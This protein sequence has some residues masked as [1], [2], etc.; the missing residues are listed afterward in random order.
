M[1]HKQSEGTGDCL[2]GRF[3]LEMLECSS[4]REQMSVGNVRCEERK[5]ASAEREWKREAIGVV[6]GGVE[7]KEFANRNC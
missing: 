5:W 2:T 1:P 3:S 6:I 4:G 7:C